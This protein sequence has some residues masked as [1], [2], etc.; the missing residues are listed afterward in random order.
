MWQGREYFY[1]KSSHR[2]VDPT[3]KTQ[4]ADS[5][6]GNPGAEKYDLV[7]FFKNHCQLYGIQQNDAELTLLSLLAN[8][9]FDFI[10]PI[11]ALLSSLICPHNLGGIIHSHTFTFLRHNFICI[12][13]AKLALSLLTPPQLILHPS[14]NH[15]SVFVFSPL[16]DPVLAS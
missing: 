10:K 1:P 12:S 16:C 11:T 15:S 6:F 2:M 8:V 13:S 3:R 7:K 9:Y 5:Q 4:D 14:L